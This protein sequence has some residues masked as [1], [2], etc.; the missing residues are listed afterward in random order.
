MRLSA[1][2]VV[3]EEV[4]SFDGRGRDIAA[5]LMRRLSIA[6]QPLRIDADGVRDFATNRGIR[7]KDL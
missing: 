1:L 6:R 2:R 5:I 7:H 4:R 3:Q